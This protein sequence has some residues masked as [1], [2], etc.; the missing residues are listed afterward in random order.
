MVSVVITDG[1][2]RSS[3]AAARSLSEGGFSVRA[4]QTKGD[5]PL[6]PPVFFSRH[7]A[8]GRWLEG[9][10]EDPEYPE[11]LLSLRGRRAGRCCSRWARRR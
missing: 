7:V 9:S 6:E 4:V 11:R 10:A 5:C 3:I 1:K 8:Q 2:Y